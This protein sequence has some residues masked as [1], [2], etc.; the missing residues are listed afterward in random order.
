VVTRVVGA[1]GGR[2]DPEAFD[3]QEEGLRKGIVLRC[4]TD[5]GPIKLLPYSTHSQQ[6]RREIAVMLVQRLQL[7]DHDRSWWQHR[8][9]DTQ[10]LMFARG[11]QQRL[12]D[13]NASEPVQHI[14]QGRFLGSL[15]RAIFVAIGLEEPI[16]GRSVDPQPGARQ[17]VRGHLDISLRHNKIDIVA[18]LRP[19]GYPEGIAT[20]QREGDAVGFQG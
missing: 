1:S 8:N 11:V 6:E 5:F 3:E 17:A 10:D 20:A 18:G 19:A 7:G 9:P 15:R 12:G 2:D 14:D 4:L 13:G 16:F